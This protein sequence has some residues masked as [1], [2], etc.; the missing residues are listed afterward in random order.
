[1]QF[2]LSEDQ[3]E[4]QRTVRAFLERHATP[5]V[6]RAA[7]E[8]E[9]GFAAAV[10]QRLIGEME[11]TSL[12]IAADHGGAGAT[13]IEVGIALEELARTL[14]P[15]PFL[16]TVVAA[17]VIADSADADIAPSLL[18]RIAGGE[19]ATIS[20]ADGETQAAEIRGRI[21]VRGVITH[22]PDGAHA[23]LCVLAAELDDQPTLLA[24]ELDADGVAVRAQPTLDQ[25][26]RQATVRLDGAAASRLSGPGLGRH[27]Q[28]HARDL[29]AVAYATESVGGAAR[30][31][32]L[33]VAYLGERVQFGRPIGS[34][35]A[36]RHRCADL[37][38][39]LEAATS[40]ARYAAWVVDG[41]PDELPVVAPLAQLVCGDAFMEIAAETIQ[42]HGGIGFTWEHDAH[43]FFKRAKSNELLRGRRHELRQLVADRAGIL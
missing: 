13:F 2:E 34:F 7:A 6:V 28:A 27:A 16:P 18:E 30:C 33:T 9:D 14:L 5:G 25:T 15:V 21:T 36:L 41:A 29:L 43:L 22:V 31:L 37:L 40:A 3:Q 24:V 11:L 32:E 20:V 26:R 42:L 38:V 17:A 1:M 35:Q 12:A 8:L 19:V 23:Q 39:T 10:W 4:L